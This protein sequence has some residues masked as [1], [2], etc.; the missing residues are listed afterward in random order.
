MNRLTSS[1]YQ[2]Y[3]CPRRDIA[4]GRFGF[5]V[6]LKDEFVE[7]AKKQELDHKDYEKYGMDVLKACGFNDTAIKLAGLDKIGIYGWHQN[8]SGL[9]V[10]ASVPG[11]EENNITLGK[12]PDYRLSPHNVDEMRQCTALF[13]LVTHW[14]TDI[15]LRIPRK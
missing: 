11:G 6:D 13:S 7:F 4:I 14:L 1:N 10:R 12:N 9:L 5:G 2:S 15:E 8:H 3:F